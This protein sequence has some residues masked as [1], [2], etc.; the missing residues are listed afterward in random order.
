VFRPSHARSW[1]VSEYRYA[2]RGDW[3][4]LCPFHDHHRLR[5]F[6]DSAG[7]DRG[8]RP[9]PHATPPGGLCS[10]PAEL[11]RCASLHTLDLIGC[12]GLTS[13][14]ASIGQFSDLRTLNLE[15]CVELAT[16]PVQIGLCGALCTLNLEKCANLA[17]LPVEIGLCSA[18]CTLNL[19]GCPKLVYLPAEIGNCENLRTL[20]LKGCHKLT[21]LPA[22]LGHC[23]CLHTLDL[24]G[25]E[26]LQ[27]GG[28]PRALVNSTRPSAH[29]VPLYP[30][31]CQAWPSL[32]CS[33]RLFTHTHVYPYS[34]RCRPASR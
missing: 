13:L 28:S 19:S 8:L 3:A 31:T 6:E 5:A 7:R 16:M 18:L 21:S 25:C 2:A 32:S 34:R 30:Y 12:D 9:P 22:E 10:L 26:A 23:T 1:A 11:G 4:L 15:G 17:M 14:P 33:T 24:I 29:S 27:A 20:I